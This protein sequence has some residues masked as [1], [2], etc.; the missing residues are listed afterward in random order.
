MNTAYHKCEQR[1]N[2]HVDAGACAVVLAGA[3]LLAKPM[4]LAKNGD[5]FLG[6]LIYAR[7]D[8][9]AENRAM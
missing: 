5:F 6:V 8:S 1:K 2:E 7:R 4:L 3:S 9:L